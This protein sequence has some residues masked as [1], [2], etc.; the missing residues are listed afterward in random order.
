M[1]HLWALCMKTETLLVKWVH[2]Y[3]ITGQCICAMEIPFDASWTTRKVLSSRENGQP[4]IQYRVG[5]GKSTF[6]WLE[7]W[8]PLWPLYKRF[9]ESMVNNLGRSLREKVSSIIHHE[10]WKW[11]RVR[12]KTSKESRRYCSQVTPQLIYRL[13]LLRKFQFG[14]CLI[15]V[16]NLQPNLPGNAFR[17]KHP[18]KDWCKVI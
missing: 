13:I 2:S 8:H 10:Q 11:P 5:N 14:G 16:E 17:P 3:I 18:V 6:L 12:S 9:G 1:R 15:L 4:L 7:N